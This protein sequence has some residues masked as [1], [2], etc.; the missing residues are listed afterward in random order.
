MTFYL[1]PPRGSI[2]LAELEGISWRR[3]SF[4]LQVGAS[5]GAGASYMAIKDLV[6]ENG[7]VE[8][9]E[10]LIEGTKKDAVGHFLLRYLR[11]SLPPRD[12]ILLNSTL[13]ASKILLIHSEYPPF[14]STVKNWIVM[15]Y[16]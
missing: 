2:P 9:S 13:A 15:I 12:L 14:S 5:S 10:C 8:H 1:L 16:P 3:L 4:L 6:E 7:T 11:H